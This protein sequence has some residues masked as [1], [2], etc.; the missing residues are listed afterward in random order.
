MPAGAVPPS[1]KVIELPACLVIEIADGRVQ[2]STHY[3]DL[4]TV[5]SQIGAGAI[6]V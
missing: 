3:F 1:G 4:M 5:L 6:G 2:R